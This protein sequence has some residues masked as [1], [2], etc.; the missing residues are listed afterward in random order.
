MRAPQR[1]LHPRVRAT[2]RRAARP[3]SC[4]QQGIEDV[5][6]TAEPVATLAD[7]RLPQ[8]C[9]QLVKV[10][11]DDPSEAD[12]SGHAVDGNRFNVVVCQNDKRI[13][14]AGQQGDAAEK[15]TSCESDKTVA[16]MAVCN[17][18]VGLWNLGGTCI[19]NHLFGDANPNC[20]N[21]T[22]S[23]AVESIAGQCRHATGDDHRSCTR[24]AMSF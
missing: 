24:L 15:E 23:P 17:F 14:C 21:N 18:T 19:V 10:S 12:Q 11:K 7:F 6:A 1:R 3:R 16:A 2:R 20:P 5:P 9:N 22:L 4:V 8:G 13:I